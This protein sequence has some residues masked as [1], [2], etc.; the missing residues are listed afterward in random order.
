MGAK[1]ATSTL[2]KVKPDVSKY[3]AEY[4]ETFGSQFPPAVR[5]EYLCT[6]P[7]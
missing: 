4:I 6:A 1:G 5:G 7:H 2:F 3:E